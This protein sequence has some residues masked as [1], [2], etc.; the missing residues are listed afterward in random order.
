MLFRNG[1][2]PAKHTGPCRFI[3]PLAKISDRLSLVGRIAACEQRGSSRASG[4]W[5]S[6]PAAKLDTGLGFGFG[7]GMW[8]GSGIGLG[9][10]IG[11]SAGVG[12]SGGRSGGVGRGHGR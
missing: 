2:N 11:I 10:G 1:S 8:V 3:G 7:L 5:D 4:P 12:R 9:T 6:E